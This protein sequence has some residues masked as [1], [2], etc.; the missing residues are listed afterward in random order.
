[1]SN[2]SDKFMTQEIRY[3]SGYTHRGS[4]CWTELGCM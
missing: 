2:K 1:M 3:I 4:V